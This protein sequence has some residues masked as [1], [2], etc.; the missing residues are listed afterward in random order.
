MRMTA[1][2]LGRHFWVGLSR[3]VT[4]DYTNNKA[5]ENGFKTITDQIDTT[6]DLIKKNDKSLIESVKH[7]WKVEDVG[8]HAEQDSFIKS[9]ENCIENKDSRETVNR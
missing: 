8:I 7:F 1:L 6:P 3:R 5:V 2:Q 9:F 4:T